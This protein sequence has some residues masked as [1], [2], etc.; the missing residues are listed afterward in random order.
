MT[1][2][3]DELERRRLD[4][5]ADQIGTELQV[6]RSIVCSSEHV[7]DIDRW[8]RAART[9]GRRLGIPVRTGVSRDGTKVWAS[10]GPSEHVLANKRRWTE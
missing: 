8:R 9:A 3:T 10:E 5:L 4:R 2:Q 7:D 1:R 6:R